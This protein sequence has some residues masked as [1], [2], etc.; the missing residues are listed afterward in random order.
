MSMQQWARG[1]GMGAYGAIGL[2]IGIGSLGYPLGIALML[3]VCG[4]VELAY[5]PRK[6]P[7]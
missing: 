3:V 6:E 2:L 7:R 5:L 4:L 1:A